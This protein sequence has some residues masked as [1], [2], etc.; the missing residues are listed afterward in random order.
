MKCPIP[1]EASQTKQ[2]VLVDKDVARSGKDTW[3][4]AFFR[5]KAYKCGLSG[6]YTFVVI[7]PK[8][9]PGKKAPLWVY[10]HGGGYGYFDK[11]GKYQTLKHQT[12][13][14]WNHEENF[15]KLA[16]PYTMTWTRSSS[17]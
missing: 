16:M 2:I 5:N 12:K 17:V 1:T 10:L 7:E 11:K 9:S 6:Y 3:Q 15:E 14:T 13:D 8:N 4:R